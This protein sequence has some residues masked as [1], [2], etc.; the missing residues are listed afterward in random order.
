MA[1]NRQRLASPAQSGSSVRLEFVVQCIQLCLIGSLARRVS[2]YAPQCTPHTTLHT[3]PHTTLHTTL[4]ASPHCV[5]SHI[6]HGWLSSSS[7][8]LPQY[9]PPL[10]SPTATIHHTNSRSACLRKN[11][12]AC[13]L[14]KFGQ[15]A[16]MAARRMLPR[17]KNC[18]EATKGAPK[19]IV[20]SKT[21]FLSVLNGVSILEVA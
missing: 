19:A 9:R 15:A 13:L 6:Q 14:I 2:H 17:A 11:L 12:F 21:R 4:R 1:G 3:T 16:P 20:L 10:R 18:S 8:V 7:T 5:P